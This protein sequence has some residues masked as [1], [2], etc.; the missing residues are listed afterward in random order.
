[1]D[2]RLDKACSMHVRGRE[3]EEGKKYIQS[4]GGKT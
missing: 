1:M 2:Y 3:E 4:F